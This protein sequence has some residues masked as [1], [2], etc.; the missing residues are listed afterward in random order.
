MITYKG[1]PLKEF[2][3]LIKKKLHVYC[4]IEYS[5]AMC[6]LDVMSEIHEKPD[7]INVSFNLFCLKCDRNIKT[8]ILFLKNEDPEE[9]EEADIYAI[10]LASHWDNEYP[11]I[12]KHYEISSIMES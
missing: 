10:I 12:C 3:D 4:E 1:L 11:S 6:S 7:F 2:I 5:A 9:H 8:K